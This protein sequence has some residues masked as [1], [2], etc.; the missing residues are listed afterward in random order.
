MI[1]VEF[2]RLV[3]KLKTTPRTGWVRRGIPNPE[4]IADHSFRAEYLAMDFARAVG[5]DPL[6]CLE[7]ITNHDLPECVAND[8]SPYCGVSAAEKSKRELEAAKYLAELSGNQKIVSLFLEYEDKETLRSRLGND[9]DQGEPLL[10]AIEYA[11]LY[12]D[13]KDSMED[14]WPYAYERLLTDVGFRYFD[15]LDSIWRA[16]KPG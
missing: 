9:A 4:S 10:Q 13:K 2:H 7:I 3:G 1:S 14:F 6:P 11:E 15:K 16:L 5:T 8:I 12:P